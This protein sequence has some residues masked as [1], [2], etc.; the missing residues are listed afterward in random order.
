M[1]E[2]ILFMSHFPKCCP[3]KVVHFPWEVTRK[4]NTIKILIKAQMLKNL[5]PNSRAKI[6]MYIKL[7]RAWLPREFNLKTGVDRR[8]AV[9]DHRKQE[10]V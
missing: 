8:P 10:S 1:V 3:E 6:N 9:R 2:I 7:T 4:T 5:W